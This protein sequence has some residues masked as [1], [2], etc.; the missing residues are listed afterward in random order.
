M[1]TIHALIIAID[2][3]PNPLHRL[4]GCK[5]DASAFSEYLKEY[6]KANRASYQE[7]RLFDA[8]AKRLSIV[9]GFNQLKKAADN[10]VCVLY[11]SGH[12]SQMP[13]PPEFWDEQ[14]RLSET[15]VCWDSRTPGGRDLIDKELATLIW[16]VTNDRD[17]HFLAVMDCCHSG[18][19]TRDMDV[20]ARRADVSTV[21][22]R[23]IKN[24]FGNEHW[25][26][27]QPPSSRHIHLAAAKDNETAKELKINELPRGAFTH[28]L[29]KIL[30]ETAGNISY[31]ALISRVSQNVKNIVKEQNPQ[32]EAFQVTNDANLTFLGSATKTGEFLISFDNTEGWIVNLGGVQGV[33]TLGTVF[34]LK[35]GLEVSTKE[36]KSNYSTVN[37]ETLK[38]PEEQHV[39]TLKNVKA[40]LLPLPVL[41]VVFSKDS[42]ESGI[43]VLKK[44]LSL[45]PSKSLQVVDNESD[46]DYIIRAYDNSYRLCKR[47][48]AV[49]LFKRE[50]GYTEGVAQ[51]FVKN[52]ETVATWKAKLELNN[53]LTSITD[54][55]FEL[56]ILDINDKPLTNPHVLQQLDENHE[57]YIRVGITNKST[58][59]FW[60]SALYIGSDFS[61]SNE[62]LQKKEL[63]PKEITWIEYLNEPKIPF[64]IQKEYLT[65]GINEIQ[66]YFKIFISTD[67]IDTSIHN[68]AGLELDTKKGA[69][70]AIG[71]ASPPVL[72]NDWRTVLIPV[73]VV[74]PLKSQDLVGGRTLPMFDADITA[75]E[76]FSAK[77]SLAST[78]QATR[79]LNNAPILRGGSDMSI[80]AFTE[81]FSNSPPLDILEID[82][83]IGTVSQDKPLKIKLKNIKKDDFVLPFGFDEK[84]GLY[85]PVGFSDDEGTVHIT[86]LPEAEAGEISRNL[87]G[88]AMNALKIYFRKIIKPIFGNYEYPMLRSVVFKDNSEEYD[89]ETDTE[90]IQKF[91]NEAKSIL[92]FVHGLI[93]STESNVKALARAAKV[94]G[95]EG[96]MGGYDL[97]LTFDYETLNTPIDVT[98]S[99]LEKKLKDLGITNPNV[100]G[101]DGGKRFDIMAHSMGCL[102]SRHFVEKLSGHNL[103]KTLYLFGAPNSGST[104]A[105]LQNML[106]SAMIFAV[107]GLS[108]LQ[109]YLLPLNIIGK[110]LNTMTVTIQQLNPK[111]DFITQLNNAPDTGI[112]YYV[113]AGNV[114]MIKHEQPKQHS[115]Y[116]KVM[117]TLKKMPDNL[118]NSLFGEPHDMAV[119]VRSARS[120]GNQT[121]VQFKEIACDHFNF[122]ET[123]SVGLVALMEVVKGEEGTI[124]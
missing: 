31:N 41:K 120:V 55:E 14:D 102:V 52:I 81:G 122:F 117:Q 84:T 107:N 28:T 73:S 1:K 75:A 116:E 88:S 59:N 32:C 74:C 79:N 109:P 66:E 48:D 93:G 65:W 68:Q 96:V 72:M 60:V 24:F 9:E 99:D 94:A 111:S 45:V 40:G 35:D 22:E 118:L 44:R 57:V 105:E 3:Y 71:L 21:V 104:L 87:G 51:N 86:H 19:N 50:Q 2:E 63:K 67:E 112:R 39:V 124:L 64:L 82:K 89:Y 121:N 30:K 110:G 101:K 34:L 38:N 76:G 13:A 17:V 80:V 92:L 7:H 46:T 27:F 49:P 42:D 70:R 43:S 16:S 83:A 97:V 103:V 33:P 37:G 106:S 100:F 115:F 62:F 61:V 18:S 69:T 8:N 4:N 54:D 25:N 6:A 53:P 78:Q 58:R 95:E 23:D 113:T 114:E 10:D 26:N 15:L 5:N 90:K 11:Y 20:K 12:G 36:V 77:I 119:P 108:F 98:A 85:L 56:T 123:D 91:V 29:I 47:G